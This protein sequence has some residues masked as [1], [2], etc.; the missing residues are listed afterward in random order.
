MLEGMNY[1]A[2]DR[3]QRHVQVFKIGR[4]IDAEV[5]RDFRYLG[6]Y[7]VA[8]RRRYVA[9]KHVFVC[10]RLWPLLADVP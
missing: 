2:H 10:L 8:L 6:L 9:L 7:Y 5:F 1:V 3:H 4:H